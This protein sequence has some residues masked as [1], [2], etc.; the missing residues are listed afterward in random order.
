MKIA[1]KICLIGRFAVGKTS[2]VKQFI[3]KQFGEKYK[4]SVGVSIS[5]KDIYIN[6]T[7]ITLVIWDIAG[8]EQDGHYTHYLRGVH[9]LIW[10]VDGTEPESLKILDIIK[11]SLPEITELPSVCFINKCDLTD[12]WKLNQTDIEQLKTFN[13][14]IYNTSAKTGENVENGFIKLAEILLD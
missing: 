11:K 4:T 9:G 8:F 13:D 14:S 1:K 12:E 10:V 5:T 3:S 7:D 2:L 6:N